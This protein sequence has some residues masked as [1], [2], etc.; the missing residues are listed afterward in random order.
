MAALG[1]QSIASSYEQL[2]HVD[3]DGGGN[4]S[5]LVNVKDG[6]NGTTFAL[7]L[8]SDKIQANGTLTGGVDDTGYDV[9]FFGATATNG[10][11]LWDESTDDLILGTSSNLGLGVTAPNYRLQ[12][13]E[14][15][16]GGA[17]IQITDSDTGTNGNDGFLVG[18]NGDEAASLYNYESTAM[19]F[20]TSATTRMTINA[21][22]SITAPAQPAFLAHPAS[23]QTNIAADN[24]AVTIVYGTEIFDQGGDFASNTFTAPVTGKYQFNV[25]TRLENVD[26]ASTY[27]HI[28]LKTSNRELAMHILDPDNFDQDAVYHMATGTVLAD[29]DASDTAYVQIYQAS[30]TAQTDISTD[31]LFSG[32]LAS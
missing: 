7:Q 31:S 9:K 13:H 23:A 27:Y 14:A 19:I 12:V 18:I 30:G 21:D 32:F 15:S 29:M 16:T 5:T 20:S 17:W 28:I 3:A 4:G 22:G 11:M 6:D 10:Y 26:T 2:L 24:S 8:A 1:S 25:L